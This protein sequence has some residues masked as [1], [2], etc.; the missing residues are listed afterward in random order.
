MRRAPLFLVSKQ[1]LS[2]AL[3]A[4]KNSTEFEKITALQSKGGQELK[5]KQITE[6]Y[7][8]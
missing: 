1:N 6:H 2:P 5:R 4:I 3:K 7:N 8:G